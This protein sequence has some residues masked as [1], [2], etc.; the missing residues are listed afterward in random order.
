MVGDGGRGSSGMDSTAVV[1]DVWPA[2]SFFSP[3]RTSLST[4]E[5]DFN[6]GSGFGF[7]SRKKKIKEF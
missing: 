1:S 4:G 3:L 5:G 7:S 2:C 6:T